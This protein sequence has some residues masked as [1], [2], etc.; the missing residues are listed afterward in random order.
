M[1]PRPPSSN[2]GGRSSG[3]VDQR[4]HVRRFGEERNAII[5]PCRSSWVRSVFASCIMS[6]LAWSELAFWSSSPWS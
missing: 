3:G 2:S 5:M 1:S 4:G 6:C